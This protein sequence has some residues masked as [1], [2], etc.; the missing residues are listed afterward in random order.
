MGDRGLGIGDWGRDVSVKCL[1]IRM[2]GVCRGKGDVIAEGE[3]LRTNVNVAGMVGGEAIAYLITDFDA[4]MRQNL[5]RTCFS[6]Q[7]VRRF[8]G[9]DLGGGFGHAVGG[10]QGQA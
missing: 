7:E 4:G 3:G 8:E 1:L 10:S 9:G 6:L 5:A 2:N